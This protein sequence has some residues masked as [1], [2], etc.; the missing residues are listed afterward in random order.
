MALAMIRFGRAYG[1]ARILEGLSATE[2]MGTG[3]TSDVL[4]N[5]EE[6]LDE[7]PNN[8]SNNKIKIKMP[9]KQVVGNF[10]SCLKTSLQ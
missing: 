3:F 2:A 8:N 1:K 5:L 4:E 7:D 6:L 10:A 9:T